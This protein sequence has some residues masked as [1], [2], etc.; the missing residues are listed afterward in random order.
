MYL[1]QNIVDGHIYHIHDQ[2]SDVLRVLEPRLVL[3]INKTGQLEFMIPP[4]HEYY[5]TIKKLKSI[6][7]VIEDGEILYEGRA[8]SD[9]ADFYNVKKIV[10]EGSMGYLIDSIQRPFSHT[11]NIRDFLAYLIDNHNR[12]V[13]ERKQFLLGTVNVIDDESNIKRE[14][15]KLEN[16][17]NTVNT[18]LISK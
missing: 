1:I 2:K 13:E 7:R 12:Q 8:I 5:N 3:T 15:T 18:Y 14:S 6:I 11:G 17:W 4:T 10:C 16:T 9:E